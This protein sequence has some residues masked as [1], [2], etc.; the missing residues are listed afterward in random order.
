M[1]NV[2]AVGRRLLVQAHGTQLPESATETDKRFQI[3]DGGY[4]AMRIDRRTLPFAA[5]VAAFFLATAFGQM[6]KD[7]S[8]VVP[9]QP[10][11][12]LSLKTF[13]GSI[14]ITS[15]DRSE[16]E[17]LATIEA[18]EDVSQEYGE[19]VVAATEIDVR[20]SRS[21]LTIRS[22]YDRVPKQRSWFSW[23]EVRPYVHYDIR[24]PRSLRLEID[25]Y[26]SEIEVFG[27][28]GSVDLETY[29]GRVDGRDWAGDIRL[30]TYKG[31]AR[32]TGL[33]GG[34]RI[35]TY[36]GDVRAEMI[37]MDGD[38]K[39]ETYKGDITLL[40]PETQRISVSADIDKHGDLRSDF[41]MRTSYA[42]RNRGR[43]NADINGGG[44][45]LSV[46]THKGNIELRQHGR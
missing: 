4:I 30:E 45:R 42:S 29:K 38:S 12:R 31:Y 44:P 25:D 35:D 11:S 19:A 20:E 7:F 1:G 39:L 36:K 18:P 46:E 2:T 32:L 41:D 15:W 6:S 14:N 28:D 33:S 10:G 16:V 34:I 8:R 24:A 21:G 17:I 9:F 40:L 3:Q 37:E 5:M 22:D 43:F 13:K 27:V 23:S 26:K